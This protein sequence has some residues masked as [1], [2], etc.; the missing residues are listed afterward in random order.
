MADEYLSNV[1]IGTKEYKLRASALSDELYKELKQSVMTYKGSATWAELQAMEKA[2]PLP[3]NGDVYTIS[4]QENREV[5]WYMA[6]GGTPSDDCWIDLG[7]DDHAHSVEINGTKKT[8]TD[9]SGEINFTLTG[10]PDSQTQSVLGS[11]STKGS[12]TDPTHLHHLSGSISPNS[13]TS[14]ISVSSPA[15]GETPTYTPSGTI[16][17]VTNTTYTLTGAN[18][19]PAGTISVDKAYVTTQ[20]GDSTYVP[21]GT[22]SGTAVSI[23]K[24]TYVSGGTFSSDAIKSFSATLG[25]AWQDVV[26]SVSPTFTTPSITISGGTYITG[27]DRN[28][29]ATNITFAGTKATI[30]S[31]FT[32][33][34][35]VVRNAKTIVSVDGETLTFNNTSIYEPTGAFTGT[36]GT[37]TA[38]YTPQ[39]TATIPANTYLAIAHPN[40]TATFKAS[41]SYVSSLA[42]K[43]FDTTGLDVSQIIDFTTTKATNTLTLT[44]NATETALSVTQPTFNG[45]G[46]CLVTEEPT[47]RFEGTSATITPKL[48]PKDTT[49]TPTFT[50][51][52]VMLKY[53]KVSSISHTLSI[54]KASTGITYTN[55]TFNYAIVD[56]VTGVTITAR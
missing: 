4:D 40:S 18:Y 44:K 10:T 31:S 22:I 5:V 7:Y 13:A 53:D 20:I 35:S 52:G 12:I 8:F 50:G 19:T 6:D 16:S 54:D 36:T 41:S 30:S 48:N 55:M 17:S 23:P 34:G 21:S 3:N 46:V 9:S 49:T 39:G 32:P 56:R 28:S 43:Q 24:S 37:A 29:T 26:S 1:K 42:V 14:T 38:T 47:A 45:T 15:S 25:D 11:V 27:V 2:T 33:S 51:T